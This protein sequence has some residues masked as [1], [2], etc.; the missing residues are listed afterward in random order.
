MGTEGTNLLLLTISKATLMNSRRQRSIPLGGRYRQVSLYHQMRRFAQTYYK[1]T[2]TR[3]S[4]KTGYVGT[5]M[6]FYCYQCD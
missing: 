2:H 3:D 4:D 1:S 6:S 5:Q